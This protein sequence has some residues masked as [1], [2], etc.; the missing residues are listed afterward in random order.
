MRFGI[1]TFLF[2]FPFTNRS[3]R[4]FPQFKKWGFET[5]EISVEDLTHFDPAYV[6]DK[7][8]QHG[9]VCGS[10]TPCLGPDKDL[11]G[12]TMQQRA[13]VAQMKRVID[14]AVELGAPTMCGV[15]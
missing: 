2:S 15:V 9:L 13:G 10:V 5:V 14:R 7:L 6:K 4:W 8:T 3:T 11:R 1:N 12:T